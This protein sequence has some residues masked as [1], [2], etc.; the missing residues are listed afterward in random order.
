[1]NYHNRLKNIVDNFTVQAA[2]LLLMEIAQMN[3]ELTWNETMLMHK[4]RDMI[5][6]D[7]LNRNKLALQK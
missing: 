4:L 1:M 5:K 2:D 7:A 3:P 6:L